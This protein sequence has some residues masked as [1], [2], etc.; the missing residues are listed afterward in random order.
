MQATVY[1]TE[2]PHIEHELRGAV[3]ARWIAGQQ[4]DQ[5]ILHQGHD[6]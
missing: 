2:Y 3:V 1:F 4:V 5:S 6:S